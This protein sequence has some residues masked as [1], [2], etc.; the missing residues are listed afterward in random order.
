MILLEP[1]HSAIFGTDF[2]EHSAW[3]YESLQ[4][5]VLCS[6]HQDSLVHGDRPSWLPTYWPGGGETVICFQ[7][8]SISFFRKHPFQN[9]LRVLTKAAVAALSNIRGYVQEDGAANCFSLFLFQK[10]FCV[11]MWVDPTMNSMRGA[12]HGHSRRI[13]EWS[14]FFGL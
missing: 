3:R 8:D 4:A 10:W 2:L 12:S 7:L 9:A 6:Q 11:L 14:C 5:D 13:Q 1:H